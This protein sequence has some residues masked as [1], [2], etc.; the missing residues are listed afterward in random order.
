MKSNPKS[1]TTKLESH[2]PGKANAVHAERVKLSAGLLS[3]GSIA[4]PMMLR[5]MVSIRSV[6]ENEDVILNFGFHSKL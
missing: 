1:R 5:R 6:G 4:N 3:D 2:Q